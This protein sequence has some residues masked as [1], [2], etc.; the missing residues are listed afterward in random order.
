[1]CDCIKNL[2]ASLTET[3]KSLNP[4]CEVI[5]AVKM[6][7]KSLSPTTKAFKL[8]SPITGRFKVKSRVQK[9]D[10]RLIFTFCPFCGEKY[11]S[12]NLPQSESNEG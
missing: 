10:D 7:N 3:M 9:F 1:M 4:G 6:T 12:E 5:E 11:I 2:E 8:F